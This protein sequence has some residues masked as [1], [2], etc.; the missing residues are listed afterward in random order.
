VDGFLFDRQHRPYAGWV[1]MV[2]GILLSVWL[3]ADQT[4]YTGL[5]PKAVPEFGDIAFFV[6]FL[7]AGALYLVLFRAQRGSEPED[8]VLVLPTDGAKGSVAAGA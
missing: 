1:S 3:F 5:V 2:V 8:A 6:G 4:L 7:I